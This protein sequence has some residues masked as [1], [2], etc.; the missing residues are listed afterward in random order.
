MQSYS[1]RAYM[2]GYCNKFWYLQSFIW[3]NAGFFCA[4]LCK[5]LHFLYFTMTDVIALK[6]FERTC[7][8]LFDGIFFLVDL[9]YNSFFIYFL[10]IGKTCNT[11]P[12]SKL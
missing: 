7:L 9:E 3:S 5:F 10:F 2:H 11:T 6:V 12:T 4:M 8:Y 1:N